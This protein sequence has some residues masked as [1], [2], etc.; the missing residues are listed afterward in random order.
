MKEDSLMTMMMMM[1]GNNGNNGQNGEGGF[2]GVVFN[3]FLTM[4]NVILIGSIDQIKQFI[5]VLILKGK[6]YVKESSQEKFKELTKIA[7][8]DIRTL[9]VVL[10]SKKHDE[11]KLTIKYSRDDDEKNE[12]KHGKDYYY[13]KGLFY[14]FSKLHH[15]PELYLSKEQFVPN[16]V[17]KPFELIDDVVCEIDNIRF[18]KQNNIDFCKI[19]ITSNKKSSSELAKEVC[20]IYN[21]YENEKELELNNNVYIFDINLKNTRSLYEEGLVQQDKSMIIQTAKSKLTFNKTK[22]YS[23]RSLENV[24]GKSSK[25]VFDRVL[26]FQNNKAWYTQKGIPYQLGCL[27]SGKPGTGKTSSIKA[28]AN[29]LKRH[30]VN[31]NFT[32]IQT[33]KQLYDL[34]NSEHLEYSENGSTETIKVPLEN[35]LYILEEIDTLGDI[36]LDRQYQ[37]SVPN[38]IPGQ[39]GLGDILNILDGSNEYPDRVIIMTSNYPERL[40]RAILRGGRIDINV[41][42]KCP[43]NEDMNEYIKFFYDLPEDPKYIFKDKILSFA[44]LSQIFFCNKSD[45]INTVINER[46]NEKE[47]ETHKYMELET[48]KY[49]DEENEENEEGEEDEEDEEDEEKFNE[50]NGEKERPSKGKFNEK[51]EEK[52]RPSKGKSKSYARGQNFQKSSEQN[53][54]YAFEVGPPARGQILQKSSEQ[55]NPNAFEVVPPRKSKSKEE[56]YAR[57][58]NFQKSS[59]QNNPYFEVGPPATS[60]FSDEFSF[61]GIDNN[62]SNC[63]Q[64]KK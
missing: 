19:I 61:L 24:L 30:I 17:N 32:N 20:K 34:F 64:F 18:D 37:R 1:S 26:F 13:M 42:F 52:E 50:K 58:Q 8:I 49:M 3:M 21:E 55:N 22:F 11:Y 57:G 33:S 48:H 16:Y 15:I 6:E 54:P 51:N 46:I 7:K 14:K 10:K 59:E 56:S 63:A 5:N 27:F 38:I 39:I 4:F 41:E 25:L 31:V 45:N 35:R 53:N 28:I 44:D 62:S 40:D 60:P 29:Q 23:N 47:L 2:Q 36:V 12:T 43:D 9:P